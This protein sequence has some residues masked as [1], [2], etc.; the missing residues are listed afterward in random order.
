[1]QIGNKFAFILRP[2]PSS[3]QDGAASRFL[4]ATQVALGLFTATTGYR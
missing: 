4:K 3:A 1:M 2:V